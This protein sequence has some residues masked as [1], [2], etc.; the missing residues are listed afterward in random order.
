MKDGIQTTEF[1]VTLFTIVVIVILAAT[2]KLTPE[3]L[4]IIVPGTAYIW[5]RT[6]VKQEENGGRNASMP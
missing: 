3:V 5:G 2:G 6:R 4:S 1:W